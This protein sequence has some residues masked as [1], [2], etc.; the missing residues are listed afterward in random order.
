MPEPDPHNED[1]ALELL[2]S[3][4]IIEFNPNRG[5]TTQ[6]EACETPL[7]V[8]AGV[9]PARNP[10]Q[11]IIEHE[12]ALCD[13]CAQKESPELFER[14]FAQRARHLEERPFDER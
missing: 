12:G 7:V 10:F 5:W 8:E 9:Y 4:W 14:L 6:C 3:S 2:R 13:A 1:E 11:G